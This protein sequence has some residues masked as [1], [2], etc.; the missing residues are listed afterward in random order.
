MAQID[1]KSALI[2]LPDDVI[3]DLDVS[4]SSVTTY[5]VSYDITFIII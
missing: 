1:I 2:G 3:L 4:L 5:G